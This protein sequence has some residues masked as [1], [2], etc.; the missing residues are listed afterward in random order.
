MAQWIGE[1]WSH[2]R[3][4]D[5]TNPTRDLFSA[6]GLARGLEPHTILASVFN[7]GVL[8]LTAD[9]FQH[10]GSAAGLTED[11]RSVV[12]AGPHTFYAGTRFG[13]FESDDGRS[14]HQTLK[15]SN[16]F[17]MGLY[18]S[19]DGRWFAGSSNEG[20]FERRRGRGRCR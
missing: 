17:V 9:G 13:I 2:R 7:Q 16:G 4:V 12:Q 5:P 6:F 18:R 3:G 14:F 15:M 1:G 20:V 19:P 10:W 8:R 11:V